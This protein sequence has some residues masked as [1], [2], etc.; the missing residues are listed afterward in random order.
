MIAGFII[1]L[2][3]LHATQAEV[4]KKVLSLLNRMKLNP[5]GQITSGTWIALTHAT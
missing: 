5:K 2:N 4:G 1:I 3:K